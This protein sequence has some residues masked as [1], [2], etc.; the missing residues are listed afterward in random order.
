[1][2]FES[3]NYNFTKLLKEKISNQNTYDAWFKETN[4]IKIEYDKAYIS[5]PNSF[6]K[7]FLSK[8]YYH[9]INE[10]VNLA[11]NKNLD[12]EFVENSSEE[13]VKIV[14]K[15]KS[16]NLSTSNLNPKYIFEDF[17]VGENNRFAHAASLA[18]AENPAKL[19]NPL[20]IYGGVGLGKTH[21]MHAI[22]HHY[23]ELNPKANVLYVSSE[24]FTNDLI[25]SLKDGKIE[26][27]RNKYRNIDLLLIDDIQFLENK[28]KTQDE[29]FHTFNTLKDANK[30]IVISS[31]EPPAKL[32]I[33]ERLT[34]RF[35]WGLSTDIGQP[36]FETRVAILRKKASLDG[37]KLNDDI[38]SMIASKITSNIRELEGS[39]LR[40]DAYVTLHNIDRKSI[41]ESFIDE[42]LKDITN[43]QIKMKLN[44]QTIKKAVATFYGISVEEMISRRRSRNISFPRQIAMYLIR[45][46]TDFSLPKIGSS[47]GGKDH[48]T[49]MHACDKIAI[50]IQTN[51][52]IKQVVNQI[53]ESL[54]TGKF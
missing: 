26:N 14:N 42:T 40:V 28:E 44:D 45:E 7:K 16:Q 9:L 12:L 18:V 53:K 50:G 43:K 8:S 39:L 36:D 19:Y 49:V 30:Q 15:T 35:N 51:P 46:L 2:P 23:Q 38:Y 31:D 6:A 1:M 48:T 47:F 24:T 11:C 20:Y 25:N 5:V 32:K 13:Y 21:L 41:D 37:I 22:G 27:F 29:F 4:I 34:S 3:I 52:E 10:V 17:V 33:E 54:E